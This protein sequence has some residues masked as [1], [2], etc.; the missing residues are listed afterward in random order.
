MSVKRKHQV[1]HYEFGQE[2]FDYVT[3]TETGE[4]IAIQ[5]IGVGGAVLSATCS[6]GDNLPSI[7]VSEGMVIVGAFTD[8][9]VTSGAILAYRK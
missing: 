1:D 6:E 8:L 7:E 2:G 3:G 9:E 4:W 5:A